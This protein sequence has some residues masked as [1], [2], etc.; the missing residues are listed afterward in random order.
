MAFAV[1]SL[2]AKDM[3][4][5]NQSGAALSEMPNVLGNGN[6][7]PVECMYVGVAWCEAEGEGCV[8]SKR[9][10]WFLLK[11]NFS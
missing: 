5:I 9:A 6:A 1:C 7:M 4:R 2:L 3:Y 8:K 11:L 10:L